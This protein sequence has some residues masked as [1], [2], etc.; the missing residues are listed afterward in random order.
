MILFE[1]IFLYLVHV[2]TDF[3][4]CCWFSLKIIGA[5]AFI[6]Y[7]RLV[8]VSWSFLGWAVLD[9]YCTLWMLHCRVFELYYSPLKCSYFCFYWLT[10]L[11]WTKTVLGSS[12]NF[13]LIFSFFFDGLFVVVVFLI[14]G[15][16]PRVENRTEL[17]L[18]IF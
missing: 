7:L 4:K 1:Y 14:R 10:C 8:C 16:K 9:I 5:L 3:I 12:S 11:N 2:D 18:G 17:R 13:G 15:L 6:I